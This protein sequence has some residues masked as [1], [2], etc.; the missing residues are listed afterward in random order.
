MKKLDR[1][2]I[3]SY[4]PPFFV[5]FMIAMFVLLMQTL[6]LYID[7]IAGKGLGFFLLMELLAYRSVS[8]IPMALPLGILISS[9]MVLGNLAENY[10]LSSFKS[11]GVTLLRVMRSLIIF[12]IFSAVFS[13][14]CSNNLIPVAN[15]K[16]GSRMY[17]IQR[18][19]PAFRLDAGV[20]NEDFQ[21]YA[22]HIGRKKQDGRSIENVLIY[23]HSN[24][25]RDHLSSVA[26]KTGEFFGTPDG[27]YF[28]MELHDG[29]QYVEVEPSG[30]SNRSF[31]FVRTS[32]KNW[33]KVFDLSE[34]ELSRTNEELF[35]QNRT[36]MS[37]A[38]LREAID[39]MSLRIQLREKSFYDNI[40]GY[41]HYIPID[42]SV[43]V[44]QT[45]S[46]TPTENAYTRDT[47]RLI[48][49]SKIETKPIPH[50]PADSTKTTPQKDSIQ[51]FK[52]RQLKPLRS[53]K[54][55]VNPTPATIVPPTT[56]TPP[57]LRIYKQSADS[58]LLEKG[59]YKSFVP[60]ER[61]EISSKAKTLARGVMNQ[62]ESAARALDTIRETQ[63]KHIFEL[64]TK[65]SMA[66]VC[67]I[68]IFIGAPMGAIVRKGGFGYP[69]LVSIIFFML[70]VIIT[71][72]CRKIAETL[73]IPAM[74][75]AW[76]P[77]IILFPIGL[78]LTYKA[79]NDVKIV[80]ID[81]IRAYWKEAQKWV[82][83]RLNRA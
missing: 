16:F 20:F 55:A 39:S 29:H 34:F 80:N 45:D 15:L 78:F 72:F 62:S 75:A 67:F 66:V 11:A 63:A 65:S 31:P 48:E 41:Y 42:S 83:T 68:F 64:W 77:C 5:T 54:L 33:T 36:M 22:I 18:Q 57:A 52:A 76:L 19:K 82:R 3:T 28:I 26:A 73:A 23:D 56:P 8:L 32:F 35:K 43:Q 51:K 7:D 49:A 13:Y 38:Q 6:W 21:G 70:F 24:A 25:N 81:S 4:I 2:L 10:E 40:K 44:L 60:N 71:I 37:S 27:K 50:Q 69:I 59:F 12:S 74:L 58:L 46:E 53:T 47:V 9:V 30:N 17:D 1:L 14:F 61:R 79:M